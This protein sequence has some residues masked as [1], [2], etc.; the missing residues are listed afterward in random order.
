MEEYLKPT[1][2]IDSDSDIVKN[3]AFDITRDSENIRE[4]AIDIFYW[5]RDKITYDAY[6][7]TSMRRNYKASKIM[8]EGRGWCVQKAIVLAALARAV[9]IPAKLHFADIRNYQTPDKLKEKIGTNIFLYHGF[10]DLYVDGKWIKATPAFNKELCEKFGYK[11]VEFDGIHDAIL[12]DKTLNGE[13]YVEYLMDR[14]TD[15]DL[16]FKE[17]FKTFFEEYPMNK[18]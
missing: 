8:Q 3:I 16:P 9:N 14:G 12:P 17:I 10:T 2:F 6:S 5:A 15:H 18:I 4:K 1:Y 13:K 11:T 7:L